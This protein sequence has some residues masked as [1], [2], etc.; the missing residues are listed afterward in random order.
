MK[1]LPVC[2]TGCGLA[3]RFETSPVQRGVRDLCDRCGDVT[4]LR[5]RPAVV[6]RELVEADRALGNHCVDC[7]TPCRQERCI[8][9]GRV[10]RIV[11]H[12]RFRRQVAA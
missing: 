5:H 10:R 11:T 12:R 4:H 7:N 1:L 2:P 3:L 6:P 8:P 9:C